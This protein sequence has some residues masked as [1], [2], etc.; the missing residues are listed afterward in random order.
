VFA[1]DALRAHTCR[2][3]AKSAR[4]QKMASATSPMSLTAVMALRRRVDSGL[5]SNNATL[6]VVVPTASGCD[7]AKAS[8][9]QIINNTPLFRLSM[10]NIGRDQTGFGFR[11]NFQ[12]PN[13]TLAM[14]TD[15][16]RHLCVVLPY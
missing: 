14:P 6:P 9:P 13:R 4:I 16:C 8:A 15:I 2:S 11:F 1:H 3:S 12:Q 10:E 7:Q 5:N